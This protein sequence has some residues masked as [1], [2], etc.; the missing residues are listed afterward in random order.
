MVVSS[1]VVCAPFRREDF[2]P[3]AAM[4]A[5]AFYDDPATAWFVRTPAG[6][7]CTPRRFSAILAGSPSRS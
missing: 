2:R 6:G 7:W 5:R 4:L 3:L 1:T